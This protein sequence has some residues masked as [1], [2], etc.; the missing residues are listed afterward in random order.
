MPFGASRPRQRA[1]Y[2][3]RKA[4]TTLIIALSLLLV[5][6]WGWALIAW[7]VLLSLFIH[8]KR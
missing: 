6:W 2:L 7:L 4:C 8:P 3:R 5:P 1:A